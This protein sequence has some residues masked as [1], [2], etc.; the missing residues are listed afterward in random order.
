LSNQ[1][2]ELK[3]G[4]GPK[5]I[6]QANVNEP[7]FVERFRFMWA[8]VEK[9][10]LSLAEMAKAFG[11]SPDTIKRNAALLKSL[12]FNAATLGPVKEWYDM[13]EAKPF[14]TWLATKTKNK[15]AR[16]KMIRTIQGFHATLWGKKQLS[17]LT[18]GDIVAAVAEINAKSTGGARFGDIIAIRALIRHGIGKPEW[19]TKHLDTRGMKYEPRM[20]PELLLKE[21][22]DALLP[23]IRNRVSQ[24]AKEGRIVEGE[25]VTVE[26]AK[27]L[28]LIFLLKITTGIRTG[29]RD[30]E[31][32]LWGTKIAAGQ[33]PIYFDQNGGFLTWNVFAKRGEKWTITK[34]TIPAE[35]KYW[36]DA[37]VKRYNLKPGDFLI[38]ISLGRAHAIRRAIMQEEG[39]S[40][41]SF[42]D[43]R[44]AYLTGLV[45]AGVPLEIA[46]ELNV[47]WRDINTART[48]YLTVKKL[49]ATSE[50]LKVAAYLNLYSV[51]VVNPVQSDPAVPA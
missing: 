6:F 1:T 38:P 25:L 10:K 11:K 46:V 4:G 40:N 9:G 12:D 43:F 13:P 23:R 29:D 28:E 47:G 30:A 32:E 18:E 17:Q 31:R 8:Q 26:E 41:L 36:L 39:F 3:R 22:F 51:P 34:E 21:S 14:E 24:M 42:H 50:Y 27:Q 33:S 16:D 20:P 15:G 37:H 48:H 35:V 44:K 2:T 45:L 5:N 7:N 49:N 19:L